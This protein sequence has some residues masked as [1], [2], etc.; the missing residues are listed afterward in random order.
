MDD[1]RVGAVLVLGGGI[2]GMQS[3][4]DL[5]NAGFKV[6]LV[7]GL[8][9]LGGMMAR[10]DKT[11]PTGDCA[12]CMISPK[13]VECGR[14]PN[15]QLITYAELEKL[16]GQ[17][18]N[19]SA[20]LRKKARLVKENKCNGCG[21]C[22]KVCPVRVPNEFNENLNTRPAIY[23]L[24]PQAIPNTYTIDRRDTSPCRIA[25][26]GGVNAHGYL[27][28]TGQGR[29]AEAYVL[30]KE[31]I[32]LPGA[33]SRICYHPC[34]EKCNRS[35]VDQPLAINSVKRFLADYARAHPEEIASI[36]NSAIR[37]PQSAVKIAVV[38]SGPAGLSCAY[39]LARR[40]YQVTVFEALPVVG[41]MLRVGI[42]DYRLPKN[43]LEEEVEAIK[44]LGVEIKTNTLIKNPANLLKEY[45]AVFL[46]TGAHRSK[47]LP[48][49]PEN[50]QGVL[51]GVE[52]LRLV[53]LKKQIKIGKKVLVIGGG[54]V[55]VD[56][57]RTALRL[58][59]AEVEMVCLEKAEE[60]PA[61]RWEIEAAIEEG[62]KINCSLGPKNICLENQC[63]RALET[64]CCQ[65]VFDQSGRFNPLF[66]PGTVTHLAADTLIVAIG[67]DAD[68]S[69]LTGETK[70]TSKIKISSRKLI[71]I[72]P[73]TLATNLPGVFA[74]GEAADGPC[75][76]I[77]AM[78][79]GN[80]AAI[81][82]DRY[83][84]EEDL[85]INRRPEK[86]AAELPPRKFAH[87]A[88]LTRNALP[89]SVRKNNFQEVELP[90]TLEEAKREAERCLNC[91]VCCECKK[92]AEAC[93]AEAVD[94]SMTDTFPAINVGA[95]VLNEGFKKFDPARKSEYGWGRFP[96]VVSSTEFERIL[97]ASGPDQGELRRPSD[98]ATPEKIAFIQCVGSRDSAIGRGLCSA[99]CC[100]Y[101]TKEAIVA[102]EHHPEV[103]STIFYIDIRAYGK[104][105]DR[106]VER[107]KNDYHVRYIKS[108][109]SKIDEKSQ[110]KNLV[111]RYLDEKGQLQSEEFDLV[112]LAVGLEARPE[113][114]KLAGLL[115]I[116]L[117][118]Y[119]FCQTDQWTPLNTS[120]PGIFVAGVYQGPKDIPESVTQGSA[121]AGAA[122]NFL[123]LS[124]GREITEKTYPEELLMVNQ[125]PRIGV[126][127]CHCGINIASVVNV[128]EVAG[129]ARSLP[130]VVY[131]VNTLYT[132]SSDSLQKIKEMIKEYQ[133]NRVV[134]ASCTP[135]THEPLFQET[136]R[137]AGLNKY[138]FEMADIREQD[139]WVHRSSPE[140]ATEKARD[141]VR[142]AIAKARRLEPLYLQ[143]KPVVKKALVVGGGV[144]GMKAALSLA[145]QNVEVILV[146]KD[147]ELG[148]RARDLYFTLTGKDVQSYL[149]KLIT[150][151]ARHPLIKI[152]LQGQLD[153]V[154]DAV[155]SFKIKIKQ[156]GKIIEDSA[157]AIIVASGGE[158][159]KPQEYL[160]GR[161][162]R[163]ITQSELERKLNTP[164][165][166]VG[167][168][169]GKGSNVPSIVMIQCVGS[170]EEEHPYCSRV[171]CGEAVKNALKIKEKNPQA[172]IYV[173]YRDIRTYGFKEDFYLKAREAG[174]VFLRYTEKNKPRLKQ[175]ADQ[176][177]IKI[178]ETG[179]QEE[180]V[181]DCNLLV[182]SSAIRPAAGNKELSQKLKVPLNSDGFFV[183]AH[184][185]LRPVDFSSEGIFVCGLAHSPKFIDEN[186]VQAGAAAARAM[187]ILSKEYLEV[188]GVV[189]KV[190]E[191]KC[192]ACLTCLR[193]CPYGAPFI[194]AKG[195]SEIEPAKCQGCGICVAEC[196][197]KALQLS[198]F[199]DEQIMAMEEELIK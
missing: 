27:A 69:Y 182:L 3:S 148:G 70:S 89:A 60:M 180:L 93:K 146:E 94:Y 165:P 151:T 121:A 58:G 85:T 199:K 144:S 122:G 168:G 104:D 128:E 142:M 119:Q 188:G 178:F 189:S 10:L 51:Y 9:A 59:A 120:R 164:S 43:I 187:T 157:G 173:L 154:S 140:S 57:A 106:Y 149:N 99:V 79:A 26:P 112:V 117:N 25:C 126:F 116:E 91:S 40:G 96:N 150:Q 36:N 136:L 129:Y 16:T 11:F 176:M 194:N 195:K 72:N 158:E 35:Q 63:F 83:C 137:E 8:P 80:E 98:G 53:N 4:L 169:W 20:Q 131:A 21:D 62:V 147:P 193:L 14:H 155:G 175:T 46:A 138:L 28:L 132:C 197:A 110:T 41:G 111:I 49:I 160:Y 179:L 127:V 190:D 12:M 38:G 55:A 118:N 139:A 22:E 191:E 81:S 7:E 31:S 135:R 141:L 71:E 19:F 198:G 172:K 107:A 61:H 171:C 90:V 34:E 15:I 115:G 177:K 163:V 42:L 109:V 92:C 44:K 56:C 48:F 47:R 145:E 192:V 166:L 103:K 75:S 88:R 125:Q 114:T 102:Q 45:K 108:M 82:I 18:G 105:F 2:A 1:K 23:R 95:V 29:Y 30:I 159:Y 186:I 161:D 24:Y 73:L 39:H 152:Y 33:I 76:A 174:V 32:P 87:S 50:V 196:P 184:P 133:L 37:I 86:K 77:Q 101:S 181:L 6:Y 5:A 65:S 130:N 84:Q 162:E 64:I 124:R 97:S 113:S 123:S 68:L 183:E 78:G 134:V 52:F 167:E 67:Q 143:K 66:K 170:R 13:L 185:K 100:M 153:E 74:G 17:A 156:D 54:N